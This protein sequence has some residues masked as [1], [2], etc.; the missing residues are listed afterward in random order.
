MNR[1]AQFATEYLVVVAI[2]LSVITGFLVYIFLYY[3]GYLASSSS[4][5]VALVTT[6]ITQQANYVSSQGPGAKMSFPIN[7]PALLGSSSYFC[8]KYV[9]ATAGTYSSISE[10]NEGLSGVFPTTAGNYVVYALHEGSNVQIGLKAGIAYINS[11]YAMNGDFLNYSLEFLNTNY[12]PVPRT[13]FNV[14]VFSTSG[15]LIASVGGQ[16]NNNGRAGGLIA[17]SNVPVEFVIDVF[18]TSANVFAPSCFSP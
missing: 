6:T 5:Q 15:S 1:K 18:A 12:A 3:S 10:A 13:A 11:T 8:G 16:S 9:K 2:A 7:F 14:S 17:L 4:N